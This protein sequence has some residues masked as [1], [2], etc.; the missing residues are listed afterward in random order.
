[1]ERGGVL[2]VAIIAILAVWV[3]RMVGKKVPALGF[4]AG[5]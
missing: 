2:H 1:M 5:L 4:L 3:A